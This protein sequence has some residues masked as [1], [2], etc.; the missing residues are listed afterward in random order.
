[1]L[2]HFKETLLG[3]ICIYVQISYRKKRVN[4]LKSSKIS[5]ELGKEHSTVDGVTFVRKTPDTAPVRIVTEQQ[6]RSFLES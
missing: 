4:E 2:P 5:V 3:G 1:M 6:L